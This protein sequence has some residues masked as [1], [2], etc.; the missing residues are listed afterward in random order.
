[1]IFFVSFVSHKLQPPSIDLPTKGS[2]EQVR[3]C[4]RPALVNYYHFIE[5]VR[6]SLTRA[7]TVLVFFSVV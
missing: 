3:S 1:M 2:L 6:W 5:L 7:L 4:R